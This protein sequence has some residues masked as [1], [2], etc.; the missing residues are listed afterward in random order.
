MNNVEWVLFEY[1]V[2]ITAP[3]AA[4]GATPHLALAAL[5]VAVTLIAVAVVLLH[6]IGVLRFSPASSIRFAPRGPAV[7]LSR[8]VRGPV[9]ARAPAAD[10]E[11]ARA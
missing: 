1:L 7:P 2:V 3:L 8:T 6:V 9:R 5:V 4:A 10:R 11:P